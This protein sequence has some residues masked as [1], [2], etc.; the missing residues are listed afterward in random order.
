VKQGPVMNE[1]KQAPHP[2]I[3]DADLKHA[4]NLLMVLAIT[5]P[6][7]WLSKAEI[8]QEIQ[9]MRACGYPHP[10]TDAFIQGSEA[11]K[12]DLDDLA[13]RFVSIIQD[14]MA[15]EAGSKSIASAVINELLAL[16][17]LR[18]SALP[19]TG[20]RASDDLVDQGRPACGQRDEFGR[21]V[22]SAERGGGK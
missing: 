11:G 2:S 7:E 22:T 18:S 17:A 5:P 15:Q 12:P 14:G 8:H 10:M 3:L 4:W 6:D 1:S 13:D 21:N 9:W 20:E 16:R 19:E